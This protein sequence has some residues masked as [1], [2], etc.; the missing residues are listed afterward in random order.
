MTDFKKTTGVGYNVFLSSD[1]LFVVD[2]ATGTRRADFAVDEK[3]LDA[4]RQALTKNETS[5]ARQTSQRDAE[6]E[7]VALKRESSAAAS[8]TRKKTTKEVK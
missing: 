2:V 5:R 7:S 1:R 4:L 6:T 8:R 3:L